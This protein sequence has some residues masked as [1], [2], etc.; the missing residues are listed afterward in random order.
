MLIP[1]RLIPNSNTAVSNLSQL[2]DFISS[3]NG[4]THKRS[5]NT[6]FALLTDALIPNGTRPSADRH[7]SLQQLNVTYLKI[8]C[9]L[10]I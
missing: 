3:S 9:I 7:C 2:C 4:P 5:L 6:A 10:N 8:P 1:Q